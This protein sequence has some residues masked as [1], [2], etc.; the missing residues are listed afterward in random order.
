MSQTHLRRL[1]ATV[2]LLTASSLALATSLEHAPSDSGMTALAL[3]GLAADRMASAAAA[4]VAAKAPPTLGQ[5]GWIET[6]LVRSFGLLGKPY[7]W[8][9][10]TPEQGFDC[11]GL[12]KY[13]LRGTLDFKLPRN[14]RD[15]ARMDAEHVRDR[16]DLSPGDLVFF[17]PRG[18][19]NH[20]GIYLGEGRFVHAPSRGKSVM[21]SALD[22]GYWNRH[23]VEALRVTPDAA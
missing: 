6:V 2:V 3:P 23:Y 13:V 12:V 22:R 18:R 14:S 16:S 15:M 1:A 7:R 11:S 10:S 17:G 21:V 4:T 9:G 20:V 5:A 8:G 19:I